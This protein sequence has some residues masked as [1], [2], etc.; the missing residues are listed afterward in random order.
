MRRPLSGDGRPTQLSPA[1][2]GPKIATERSRED[3]VRA[4]R[5]SGHEPALYRAMTQ[6]DAALDLAAKAWPVFPCGDDKRPL[7]TLAEHG[8]KDATTNP[9]RIKMW[10][11]VAPDALIGVALVKNTMAVD[12]D[13]VGLFE[14]SGLSLPT[15]PEQRTR[16]GG[17]HRLY[18]TDPARVVPQTVKKHPGT[19]TRIG[20]RGYI[21]GWSPEIFPTPDDLPPAPTG[22]TTRRTSTPPAASRRTACP[23]RSSSSARTA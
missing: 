18:A 23:P 4:R 7:G 12:V 21:I 8:F 15:A 16:S 5:L 17:F 9:R 1:S 14:K 11:R 3:H 2:V 6:L 13:N 22:S 10:W 19:D 20:G